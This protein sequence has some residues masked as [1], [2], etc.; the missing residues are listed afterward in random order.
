MAVNLS[1]VGGVAAQFFTNTGAVLT[2]GKLF[3][4]AAGTTTPAVTYTSSQG[5]TAHAN[6]IV[7]DAA[8]R[9]PSGE[10]WLTDGLIYKF[11]LK[12]S[13]DVLIATYDNISGINSNFVAFVNQQEIVTATAGQTVFNLS[14]S[15]QPGTNSLS[16]FVDGVNQYGPGAQYAYTETDSDTVTFVSGL[17]VG[18]EVKFTTTQ[19]QSAGAI[20]SSQVTYDPPFTGSVA[21]N[22]EAK[23]AQY[24]SA[25]DFGVV[26]N[27]TTDDTTAFLAACS[28]ARTTK[29]PLDI[30]N[31]KIYLQTQAAPISTNDLVLFGNGRPAPSV[32][33]DYMTGDTAQ[34]TVVRAEMLAQPG[35]VIISRYNGYVF[36]GKKFSGSGFSVL[37]DPSQASN[38]CFNTGVPSAYPGWSQAFDNLT[39]VGVYYFGTHGL[40][41]QAGLEVLTLSNLDVRYC[42]GNCLYIAQT[43]G[44]NSPIE[45]IT[46]RDSAFTYGLNFNI[47]LQGVAKEIVI[48]NCELNSP[49]QLARVAAETP[50]FSITSE[51]EI[52]WP[53]YIQ[54]ALNPFIVTASNITIQNCYAE[55]CQGLVKFDIETTGGPPYPFYKNVQLLNNYVVLQDISWTYFMA[56]F[57][58]KI[59]DLTTLSNDSPI[60]TAYYWEA[61]GGTGAIVFDSSNLNIGE[62]SQFNGSTVVLNTTLTQNKFYPPVAYAST[63]AVG[64]GSAGTFTVDV[65][66]NF[67]ASG[68]NQSEPFAMYVIT[69]NYQTSGFDTVGGYLMAVT[70]M[71]SGNFVAM[72]IAMS[73]TAAFS[74]APTISTA[75]VISVPLNASIRGRVT[76]L[77]N[78][79][80]KIF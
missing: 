60:G 58:N 26:G 61:A 75:G 33:W 2:G 1:P 57:G 53:I 31:L 71:P 51:S 47:R 8:G 15:F 62:L 46:I 69:G 49:G 77:D 24:V 52:P 5:T 42:N 48:D 38:S 22:V 20:D 73:S 67:E 59:Y 25:Q 45:Y 64:T 55:E 7:L 18:A 43:V 11:V 63:T 65:S 30:S 34:F 32:N 70:K 9:V 23:L 44:V 50:G 39:N 12:D 54:P 14:I 40:A 27:G 66:S 4:Y 35:S 74:S 29:K 72:T 80:L 21:T 76:R 36:T 19:Q 56:S 13:N 28:Y 3:T 37:G 78:S 41:S 17:H 79:A 68:A 10:I 16:V 6:P